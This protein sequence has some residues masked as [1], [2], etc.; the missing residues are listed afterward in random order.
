LTQRLVYLAANRGWGDL[1]ILAG[2]PGQ[3]GG[4]VIMNA[5]DIG[6]FV[7][8]VTVVSFDGA[9]RQVDRGALR[10]GYRY[11]AMDPGIVT[12]VTLQFPRVA[13][14]EAAERI[15]QTLTY[16]NR[17][18]EVRLP[19]AG[20][21]FKNPPGTSAGRL[22]DEAGLKGTRIGDAQISHRHANFIVNLGYATCDQVLSVMEY[23]QRGVRRT[24]GVP[25]E[26]EV[27]LLGEVWAL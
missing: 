20:C 24:F 27:R 23:V 22:I 26:P 16:R 19:S 1:E 12:E 9:V 7:Q 3:V 15:R 14:H 11:T 21:A 10:F 25:L 8:G 13:P 5:Q 18:Q 2:R 17:T 4:A 6:R